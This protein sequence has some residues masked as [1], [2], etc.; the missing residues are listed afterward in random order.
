M[1]PMNRKLDLMSR[2]REAY[3]GA[4][5]VREQNSYLRANSRGNEFF[6]TLSFHFEGA[7][8]ERAKSSY[9]YG[10]HQHDSYEI[11]FISKGTC[12]CE[13]NGNMLIL[14][15]NDILVIQPG[16]F[17]MDQCAPP[18]EY[19]VLWFT[20]SESRNGSPFHVLR[21]DTSPQTH[22]LTCSKRLMQDRMQNLI[23]E[24]NRHRMFSLQIQQAL[25]QEILWRLLEWFPPEI[26][27]PTLVRQ[28]QEIDLTT[29]LTKLFKANLSSNLTVK[30]MAKGLHM[31]ES[32]LAHSCSR[33]MGI[34]PAKAHQRFRL[35]R[36]AWH[37]LH[38]KESIK[39]IGLDHGFHD[40]SHF[41]RS[42]KI[43]YGTTPGKFRK[44]QG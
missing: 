34:S 32:H 24:I 31:S 40:H 33:I 41:I 39:D 35:T 11:I 20:L 37:L 42:F 13:L 44:G 38:S 25:A 43:A 5:E 36:A 26:L 17:H 1:S 27:D 18:L 28:N 19:F 2:N 7:A 16:D 21:R 4:R 8:Y 23:D 3:L 9:F 22:V 30:D 14:K 29:R 12:P 10:Q 15:Q 6:E